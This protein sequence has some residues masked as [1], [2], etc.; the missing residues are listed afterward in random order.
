MGKR[1][2]KAGQRPGGRRL[3][4]CSVCC[5][6][7][8]GH[9]PYLPDPALR[10]WHR[11]EVWR[12][13]DLSVLRFRSAHLRLYFWRQPAAGVD[14]R[15]GGVPAVS[16]RSGWGTVRAALHLWARR[17]VVG[18]QQRYRHARAVWPWRGSLHAARSRTGADRGKD[19]LSTHQLDGLES[20]SRQHAPFRS[21]GIVDWL[22]PGHRRVCRLLVFL[23]SCQALLQ[24][25]REVRPRLRGRDHC[26]G[27]RQQCLLGRVR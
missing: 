19:R 10:D 12:L 8:C 18:L 16:D 21:G 6:N 14:C 5:G 20:Q 9:D 25:K 26:G 23:R 11:P 3:F 22:H 15:L 17:I 13:G 7:T 4:H 27:S 2:D 24:A 1:P